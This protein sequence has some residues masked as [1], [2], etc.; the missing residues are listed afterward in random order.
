M[1]LLSSQTTTKET[2]KFQL[3]SDFPNINLEVISENNKIKNAKLKGKGIHKSYPY[4]YKT[5]RKT[6]R[7][8]A[9]GM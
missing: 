1:K 2:K 7:S 5:E 9:C 4:F 6:H 3:F 8:L